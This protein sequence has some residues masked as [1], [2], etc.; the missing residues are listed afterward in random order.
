MKNAKIIVIVLAIF[1]LFPF[2]AKAQTTTATEKVSDFEFVDFAGKTRKFFEFKGKI[3]LLDFW[4]TWCR[5][6]LADIPKLKTAYEKYQSQGFEIIGMDSET[7]T[8]DE[9]ETEETP[10]PEFEAQS[11]ANAQRIVKTRGVTWTQ[12]KSQ[13]AVPLAKKNFKVKQLPT[14][15]LV[16]GDGN[17]VAR[18][19]EGDDIMLAIEKL[20]AEKSK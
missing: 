1:F 8:G 15:I 5:P 16:D 19:K 9:G 14:K 12:V 2:A 7:L 3:V 4:A 17:I 11:F 20:F 6:C 18:L 10:D 13:S